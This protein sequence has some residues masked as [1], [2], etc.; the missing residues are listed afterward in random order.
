MIDNKII[1]E[2]YRNGDFEKRLN[3]YLECPSLRNEFIEIE[4]DEA[5]RSAHTSVPINTVSHSRKSV[6]DPCKRLV[7]K[8]TSYI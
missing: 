6:C 7:S 8:L 5:A 1:V 3:L 4:Q 2:D